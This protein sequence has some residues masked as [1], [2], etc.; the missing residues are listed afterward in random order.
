MLTLS[1]G[2]FI[3]YV[4]GKIKYA[5]ANAGLTGYVAKNKSDIYVGNPAN[6]PLFNALA[7]L[8]VSIPLIMVPIWGP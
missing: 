8:E 7:D 2:Q 6:D 5:P 4:N 3:Y 1:N